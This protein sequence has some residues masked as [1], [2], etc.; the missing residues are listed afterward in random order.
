VVEVQR[1]AVWVQ[2]TVAIVVLLGLGVLSLSLVAMVFDEEGSQGWIIPVQLVVMALVGA[3]VGSLVPALAGVG[4]S[5]RRAA[6]VGAVMGVAGALIGVGLFLLL[7]A[8][9]DG[10]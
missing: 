4:A 2:R 3:G 8:G 10:L 7:L 5:R 9:L 1:V 6:T